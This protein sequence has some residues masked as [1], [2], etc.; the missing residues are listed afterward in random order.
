MLKRLIISTA[1]LAFCSLPLAAQEMGG[2]HMGKDV[3]MTGQV[4]DLSCFT[5]T[6]ASGP[7]HK[8][9][10]AACAKSGMPLAILS[11]DGKLYMLASP[12]PAD[13]QNSPAALR[14]AEG[15]GH[16]VGAGESRRQHDHDQDDCRRD[17][18][19]ARRWTRVLARVAQELAEVRAAGACARLD[20]CGDR[21]L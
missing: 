6:G 16:G 1:V 18:R 12:K 8:A 13:P 2:M 17:L 14:R 5:T 4:I 7:S 21:F 3:S 15:Q 9:C 20:R 19:C 11:D 10:A